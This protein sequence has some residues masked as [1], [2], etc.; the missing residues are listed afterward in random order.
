MPNINKFL[1]VAGLQANDERFNRLLIPFNR[2]YGTFDIS[3]TVADGKTN[4]DTLG[5]VTDAQEMFNVVSAF[6]PNGEPGYGVRFLGTSDSYFIINDPDNRVSPNIKPSSGQYYF[7]RMRPWQ[8]YSGTIL[9]FMAFSSSLGET[10]S[11]F[12]ISYDGDTTLTVTWLQSITDT[13]PPTCSYSNCIKPN[14]WQR[15]GK[16]H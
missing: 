10:I 7:F 9:S 11:T 1:A 14:V 3:N 8:G 2:L 4:T 13:S 5:V 16:H 6:G 12:S 15:I